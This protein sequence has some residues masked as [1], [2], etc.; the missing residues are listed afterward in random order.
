MSIEPSQKTTDL[1]EDME[2]EILVLKTLR[3]KYLIYIAAL[4]CFALFGNVLNYYFF[5]YNPGI[6]GLIS[7]ALSFLI[8]GILSRL[9]SRKIKKQLIDKISAHL[10]LTYYPNGLFSLQEIAGHNILP[11]YDIAECEDGFTGKIRHVPLS[12]QEIV[13]KA[14]YEDKDRERQEKQLFRGL[15]IRI[16]LKKKLDFH[17]LILPNSKLGTWGRTAFSRYKQTKLSASKFENKF[18]LVTT[19]PVE[20]HYIFD[21]AFTERFLELVTHMNAKDLRAS[22]MQDELVILARYRKN[23]FEIGSILRPV[24]QKRIEKVFKEIQVIVE[25]IDI[26]KLNPHI[27]I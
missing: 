16:G 13:L 10:D 25:I 18:D 4:L 8:S 12:F 9:Y 15:V 6:T 21:P 11:S 14:E 23:A 1:F 7:V 22:F 17:T 27:G 5:G 3:K 20:S 24:T 19:D 26:L 2:P